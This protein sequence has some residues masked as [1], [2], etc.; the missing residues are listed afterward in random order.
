MKGQIPPKPRPRTASASVESARKDLTEQ[1]QTDIFRDT[2]EAPFEAWWGKYGQFCRAGGGG[3]E[4]TFAWLAWCEAAKQTQQQ[5]PVAWAESDEDGE[6]VW[7]KE[8]CFSDDPEWLDH[9]MPLYRS[10]SAN[11]PLEGVIDIR[12][13]GYH[14]LQLI[15]RSQDD[16]AKFKATH[17]IKE[18]A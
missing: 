18:G 11:N 3:Y 12:S 1:E 14:S 15:F 2:Q 8:S 6:I 13:I 7:N 16:I 4:K 10:L 9:P 5:E 17:G